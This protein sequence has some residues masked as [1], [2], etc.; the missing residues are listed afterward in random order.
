M[1]SRFVHLHVHSHYSLLEALPKVKPL[2]KSIKEKGMDAFALTDNGVLYGII[3]A[4]QKAADEGIKLIVGMDAYLAPAGRHQKRAHIDTK[5]NRLVLLAE[6]MDGYR[7]LVQ[8]SSIGFL[9]GF[10]YKPRID[11]EILR[12]LCEGKSH[13][14]I[15]LSGGRFG[16]ID[17]MLSHGNRPQTEIL[18]QEYVR[19][20][21]KDH[22]FLELVDRPEMA[23]Q[24]AINA[25]LIELGRALDVP[26]VATKNVF[27]LKPEEAE[28]WKILQCVQGGKTLEHLERL[29]ATEYDASLVTGEIMEEHF[30]DVPEAIENTRRIA[31]RCQVSFEL[32]K[33][34]FAHFEIPEGLTHLQYLRERAE[35]ELAEKV[36]VLTEEMQKRLNYELSVIEMKGF[37]PYFLIV[38][39]YIEWARRHGIVTTTRGSAAGSLV[40]YAIGISTVDPLRYKLPFERF[41]NPERPSAP[42]VDGDFADNRRDEMLAYVAEKYGKEKVAQ[43]CTFGTMMARGSVRDVGR[44]LGLPY[45]FVDE[46]AKFVPMGS[47]G[48]PMTLER[49]L[50]E[51]PD[52]KKRYDT[53]PQVRRLIDLAKRIEGCAR[54]VS[55][56]AA[57]VVIAPSPLTDF[58][59]LQI[60]TREGKVITQYEMKS[61]EAAGLLK[62]DFLGIRNLSILGDAV[63]I[64]KKT[65][66][67][68][69]VLEKIPVDDEK[70]FELLAKGYTMG[71]FQLNGDGMTKYL[72][73][74]RPERIEDIMAMVAL[75]RPGPIE[76]IPEY[77][78]RKHDPSLVRYLDPRLKTILDQSY[79]VIVYQDDVMLIAIHLA[80]YSWLEADKLRKAMG[81]KIPEEMAKQKEKLLQGLAKHGMGAEKAQRLWKLIEPFAAYGFNKAHAASYGM[82]A[83]D[84]AYL[85]ANFPA[86][87]MSALMTAESDDLEMIASAVKECERIGI[88][89]LPPDINE[90]RSTF[91][92]INDETIRFGLLVIK[93][94]GEE[95]IKSIIEEREIHGPFKDLADFAERVHH[96]AFTKKSLEALIKA[97]ALDRFGER[98]QL[99]ENMEQIL[100]FNK[101]TQQ[102]KAQSQTSLFDLVPA[103]AGE[104]LRL[105]PSPQ[106]GRRELLS[107]EKEFL[108]LYVTAHPY[109]E[110]AER[111]TP[112]LTS[113]GDL[114]FVEEG[115]FV[116]CGGLVTFV[117][118]IMTKKGEPMAFVGL[119][120]GTTVSEAIFFPRV[121]AQFQGTLHE[122]RI[123]L[124]SAK[125][126]K[127]DGDS[128]KLLV[129][130]M[131]VVDETQ[132]ENVVSMLENGQWIPDSGT[133]YEETS[134]TPPAPVSTNSFSIPQKEFEEKKI[135]IT[136]EGKPS[137]ETMER[138]RILFQNAPGVC[139]VS[140]LVKTGGQNRHIETDYRVNSTSGWIDELAA[141]VGRQNIVFI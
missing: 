3:E 47:Q 37:A 87:Y 48:F 85:K 68:I 33:W 51:A 35:R 108:G 12:E 54:H 26:V 50:Q 49:A 105:R 109:R 118:P 41:L 70:T 64:I 97:G 104:K 83:Y 67:V 117:K 91:T 23:E 80:G 129:N 24:Q 45:S 44:A 22:F 36:P 74:L 95:V 57:G 122:E 90:S 72:M 113:Y 78:R 61:V 134:V 141:I 34:N 10:Y 110:I 93:N 38:S 127:K 31:D 27:Y 63:K 16:E 59:P 128:P 25:Q 8:L 135:E 40:G 19:I 103:L 130:S 7:T 131:I 55:I 42:D 52:L 88:Q 100:Q 121:Y 76:S 66:G 65:K 58:T 2:I 86:E 138:L 81:K 18:I 137:P 43:I 13:G 4:Y 112:F 69:I 98:Q 75:Y 133:S 15:A 17:Q 126:S 116:R 53:D 20:F 60:E 73:E 11:H 92:Y 99:L 21:G 132:L 30:K 89:V 123:V 77:I 46:I 32:G 120:D 124:V 29:Q 115:K 84:T 106:A 71:T 6:N 140:F 136:L 28:A 139:R 101:Q 107:W 111:L 9:E 125:I 56:H 119:D 94:L 14:L 82:I 39:D 5:P 102:R 79:G 1:P 62:M 96:R 114:P